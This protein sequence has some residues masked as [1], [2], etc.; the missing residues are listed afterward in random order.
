MVHLAEN[1][2]SESMGYTQRLWVI[3]GMVKTKSTVNIQNVI[4][5]ESASGNII[6]SLPR[7]IVKDL[8][9]PRQAF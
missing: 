2:V 3:T 7:R 6:S 9:Q 8:L 4:L 5:S 1:G